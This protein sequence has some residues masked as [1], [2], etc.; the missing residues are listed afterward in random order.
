MPIVA[1]LLAAV[2]SAAE[3]K[4]P[5]LALESYRLDNGLRVALHRDPSVPRVTVCVAYHVGAK[6]ERAGRTGFAHFFEHMM[7][8]GTKNVP[9]YDIPLQEAGAQSNAFTSEDMTVYYETVPSDFLERAL[10]LEAERLAFLP[11]SLNREKFDTERQVVKNERRQSYENVPYGLAEETLL[12]SVFPKGKPYSWSVIGSM[13]D[14]DA[15][16]LVLAGDFEPKRAK[17]LISK[18]FGPLVAGPPRRKVA[19]PGRE[20]KS[21]ELKRT[22]RVRLPRVYRAWPTVADDHT[23]APALDLLATVLAGG[24]ASRL[25]RALVLESRLA[26]DVSADSDTKEIGGLFTID[27][28]ADE[29]KSI[30]AIDRVLGA[31]LD[32]LRAEPPTKGELE[33][34]LAKFEKGYYTHLTPPLGRA[35]TLASGFAQHDDPAYYRRD[36]ARYFR[37]TPEDIRRVA[38][39]YLVRGH[40]SLVI[41]P[42]APGAEP[43][44]TTVQAGPEPE[45]AGD[46]TAPEPR[47]PK[48]GPDWSKMPGPS[49]P[50]PFHAPKYVRKT[51]SNGLDVWVC[52]WRTLPVVTASLIVDAGTA[53]DRPEK[54]G[55]ARL[56]ATLLDKGTKDRT[57]TELAEAFEALGT[58]PSVGAG[59]D[60]TTVGLSVIARN[61]DPALALLAPMLAGPRFDP[62][63]FDR[64]RQLQLAELL[65][66]PEDPG[67]IALR[68]FRAL[69]F[70]KESPYGL[71]PDGFPETVKALTLDDVRGFHRDHFGPDGS[72]LIVV[73]DVEPGA[74]FASLEETLGA[75]KR[76]AVRKPTAMA[77]PEAAGAEPGTI[78]VADKPGAV[79]SVVRVGRRWVDRADPRYFATLIGNR[80]LG[81]DFLSRLNQN[82]REEH[83][84]TYGAGSIFDYRRIGSVWLVNTSVRTDATAPALKEIL[85]ELDDLAKERPFTAAEID[86]ARDAE[87]RSYPETF[88]A[89]AGIA[90]ILGEMAIFH[91]PADYLDT[92]LDHLRAAKAD[93]IRAAM[94]E[95]VAP[96][97][98]TV[99]VVGDRKAVEPELKAL[100]RGP[101]RPVT[102]DGR[103]AR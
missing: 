96:E 35:I 66:G 19:A 52:P 4:A 85:K 54:A 74:V 57:A 8:R 64:E 76:R 62:K 25:H 1:A 7:F 98:R 73:G 93:A 33:R 39:E 46:G 61:F 78:F 69:L 103:P 83:G 58:S 31:E 90:G 43:S 9:N 77:L 34:S 56:T 87:A 92:F 99:L 30:E 36:F 15:A 101:V 48:G 88:E 63:D 55:L 75:W 10:Y 22:D 49:E 27:A 47:T 71:P 79:Q 102:P 80:V 50:L 28:T 60:H 14:L 44:P 29:G 95:L 41:G 72:T 42:V 81:A 84:Y 97:A 21:V 94:T 53:E 82:L 6:D 32:R 3:P 23:D 16:T 17:G 12:A 18:Y 26:T 51:L 86:V 2:A 13:K 89:P 100:K 59:V 67:W 70:G 11:S 45:K 91:L 24:D 40:V 20:P 5:D 68:A 65:Q 37:V 38:R